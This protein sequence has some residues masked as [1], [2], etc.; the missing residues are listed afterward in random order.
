M[1]GPK[2]P[3]KGQR[4]ITKK[5]KVHREH[6]PKKTCLLHGHADVLAAQRTGKSKLQFPHST[7]A[8]KCYPSAVTKEN[9][10]HPSYTILPA[11][12]GSCLAQQHQQP[13]ITLQSTGHSCNKSARCTTQQLLIRTFSHNKCRTYFIKHNWTGQKCSMSLI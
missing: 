8:K 7:L 12:L 13:L 6:N 10:T 2:T 1:K 9:V 11:F 3:Q 4:G 5:V